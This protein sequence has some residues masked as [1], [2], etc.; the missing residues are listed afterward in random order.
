MDSSPCPN[1]GMVEQAKEEEGERHDCADQNIFIADNVNLNR[2][3]TQFS[4]D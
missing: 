4:D 3:I 2:Q 1:S